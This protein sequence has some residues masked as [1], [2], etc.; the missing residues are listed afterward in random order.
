MDLRIVAQSATAFI[1]AVTT[2][3]GINHLINFVT[4]T[5]GIHSAILYLVVIIIIISL[6]IVI[7]DKYSD[8]Q[9]L[10]DTPFIL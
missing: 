10:T 6:V 4:T 5:T 3:E 8:T 9:T 1:I 2:T 7:T